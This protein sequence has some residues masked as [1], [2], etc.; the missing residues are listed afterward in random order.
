MPHSETGKY[1][2]YIVPEVEA[3]RK[4]NPTSEE[5]RNLSRLIAANVGDLASLRLILGIDPPEFASFYPDMEISTPSTLD[6]IDS[7]L[8]K[9]GSDIPSEG[10]VPEEIPADE[11][12]PK[13]FSTLMKEK[14]YEGALKFIESQNLNNTDKSVY[15]AHQM[16]FLKKLIAIENY[17]NQTKG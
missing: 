16:R 13:D 17:R 8:D 2:Y 9:F 3:Y 15:F 1:P 11:S 10:Y 7:F 6:T 4:L 14:D 12:E 5:A